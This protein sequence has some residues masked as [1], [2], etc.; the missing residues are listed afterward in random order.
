VPPKKWDEIRDEPTRGESSLGFLPLIALR[1]LSIETI[2][3][4]SEWTDCGVRERAGMG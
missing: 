4:P 2:D 3:A 1:L